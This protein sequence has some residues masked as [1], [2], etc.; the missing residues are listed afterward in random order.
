MC[1]TMACTDSGTLLNYSMFGPGLMKQLGTIVV[2]CQHCCPIYTH[3][4][5]YRYVNVVPLKFKKTFLNQFNP[6][7]GCR[8]PELILAAVSRT[9]IWEFHK[10]LGE[11][12]LC[13]K[14]Y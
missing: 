12:R 7:Q 13:F 11:S 5:S 10:N 2:S 1:E 9:Q 8:G 14:H 4:I 3:V 6:I